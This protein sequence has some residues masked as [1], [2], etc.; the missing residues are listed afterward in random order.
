M[1]KSRELA[2]NIIEL[3]EGLLDKYNIDI[4]SEDR[5]TELE[6]IKEDGMIDEEIKETNLSHIYGTEYFDLEDSIAELIENYML[7]SKHK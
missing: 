5:N 7:F 6:F 2:I 1:E 4:P 3:F